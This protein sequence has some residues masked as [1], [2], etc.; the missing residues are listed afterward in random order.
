MF[1]DCMNN[2]ESR[3]FILMCFQVPVI[4]AHHIQSTEQLAF[5]LTFIGLQMWCLLRHLRG[6]LKQRLSHQGMQHALIG[7]ATMT[8]VLVAAGAKSG[9]I[10]SCNLCHIAW[11]CTLSKT[12]WAV[13]GYDDGC[14]AGW[15]SP[16]TG[17]LYALID[18]AHAW[19]FIPLI[20]SMP[21]HLPTT[22]SSYV[23]D[24]HFLVSSAHGTKNLLTCPLCKFECEWVQFMPTSL[25]IDSFRLLCFI[26]AVA[27]Y[28]R[29]D[30]SFV[31]LATYTSFPFLK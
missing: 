4:G 28:V 23:L 11:M 18:P 19:K 13:C 17:R 24:L 14:E 2:R 20:A 21:D 29:H 10:S 9:G 6:V 30:T 15:L 31:D 16:W 22:W 3:W 7:A 8:L 26:I 25:K 5:N 12:W 27:G 1:L